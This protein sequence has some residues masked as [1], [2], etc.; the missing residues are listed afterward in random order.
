M[1]FCILGTGMAVPKTVLTNDAIS[2]MVDTTDEWIF[3]RTGIRERRVCTDETMTS[4]AADAAQR[5]LENADTKAEELDLIIC[6]TFR[7]DY[8]FPSQACLIQKEIGAD[9][10]AF[11]VNAA[12]PGFLYGLDVAAGYFARKK[13]KKILVVGMDV[14]SRSVD[15]Q[16]RATCVLF[17]DGGGA[18]VLGEGDG[19]LASRITASG[20]AA[21]GM[22]VAEAYAEFKTLENQVFIKSDTVRSGGT[23]QDGFNPYKT[24]SKVLIRRFFKKKFKK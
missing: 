8:V 19:L 5:A 22:P 15:W 1:S 2:A 10:P 23:V 21:M 7:G 3:S 11:D 12:C 13:A 17:G 16:D 6:G 18:V 4:L 9:C 14:I 20:N 24:T